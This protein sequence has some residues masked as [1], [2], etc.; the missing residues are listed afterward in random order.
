MSRRDCAGFEPLSRFR[1]RRQRE[2]CGLRRR[3]GL[4]SMIATF[5]ARRLQSL[6]SAAS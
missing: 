3:R 5:P 6:I 2:Y 1:L 4:M